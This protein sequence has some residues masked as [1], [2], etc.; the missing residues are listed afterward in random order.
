MDSA[1][2]MSSTKANSSHVGS[3]NKNPF[4]GSQSN[5]ISSAGVGALKAA[6]DKK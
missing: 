3:S 5:R 6:L 1:L 2:G 4:G